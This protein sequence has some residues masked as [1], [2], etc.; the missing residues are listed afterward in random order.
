MI[1]GLSLSLSL[2]L[3]RYPDI[4]VS[5]FIFHQDGKLSVLAA[6]ANRQLL[7]HYDAVVPI[8]SGDVV[9]FC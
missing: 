5:I 3:S 8:P 9:M 1:L 7:P 2:Y 4:E 6:A